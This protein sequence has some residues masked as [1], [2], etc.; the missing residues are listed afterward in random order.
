MLLIPLSPVPNQRFQVRLEDSLFGIELKT[1]RESMV[2]SISRDGRL[3]LRGARCLPAAP[4]IPF[5]Y[6]EGLTGNFFFLTEG[7]LYPHHS[8]FGGADTLWHVTADELA[9]MRNG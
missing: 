6:L 5:R 8:R 4:L 1:A 7:G 2:I 9:E 3:I